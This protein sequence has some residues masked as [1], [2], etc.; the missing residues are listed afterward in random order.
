[1]SSGQTNMAQQ[2]AYIGCWWATCVNPVAWAAY[3]NKKQHA[4][5]EGL[6]WLLGFMKL[7]QSAP[8]QFQGDP[9]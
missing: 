8:T 5:H 7:A 2:W 1:M 6:Q 9:T 4:T 3:G